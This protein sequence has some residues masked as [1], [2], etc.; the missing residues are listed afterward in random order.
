MEP[1]IENELEDLEDV[2]LNETSQDQRQST[3]VRV[4]M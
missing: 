2:M 3:Y 4:K 1:V